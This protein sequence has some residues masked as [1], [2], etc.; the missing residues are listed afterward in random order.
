MFGNNDRERWRESHLDINEEWADKKMENNQQ[1]L[2]YVS[3]TEES[4]VIQGTETFSMMG[5]KHYD[6]AETTIHYLQ[7]HHV[8]N[9]PNLKNTEAKEKL[10]K[11]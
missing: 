7:I 9:K 2:K 10:K 11:T 4:D 1:E 3:G 8:I 6:I 5:L